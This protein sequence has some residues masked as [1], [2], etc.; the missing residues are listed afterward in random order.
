MKNPKPFFIDHIYAA[1]IAEL[2]QENSLK[3]QE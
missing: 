3:E 1:T 2:Y